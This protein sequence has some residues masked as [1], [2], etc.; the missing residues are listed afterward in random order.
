MLLFFCLKLLFQI[1]ADC[2]DYLETFLSN[3]GRNNFALSVFIEQQYLI[4]QL[5]TPLTSH[6]TW[7]KSIILIVIKSKVGIIM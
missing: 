6:V 5:S 2:S 3:S 7:E 1:E 4:L